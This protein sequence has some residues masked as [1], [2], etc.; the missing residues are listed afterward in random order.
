MLKALTIRDLAIVREL[1]VEF[2][3]GLTVITGETGAGKS[4]LVDA[5]GL[6]LG[7][8]ADSGS[9][10]DGAERATVTA[11][12][13]LSSRPDLRAVLA[14]NDL[15]A[16]DD[17]ILRRV[18]GADGRSRAFC[19]ETP[20]SVQFLKEFGSGLVGIHGQHAHHSLLE[21]PAQRRL[22]DEFGGCGALVA[23]VAGAQ[24]ACVALAGELAAL[25][26]EH[27]NAASRLDFLRFQIDELAGLPLAPDALAALEAEH[28]KAANIERLQAGCTDISQ[29][30]FGDTRG[31]QR[32]LTHALHGAQELASIDNQ[33][34]PLVELLEQAV[35]NLDEAERELSHYTGRLGA[36]GADLASLD[37]ALADLHAAA[38]KHRCEP[39][40][41]GPFR[42]QLQRELETLINHEQIEG[43]TAARLQLAE[44]AFQ[45][46]AGQLSAAR[47][48]AG[49]TLDAAV[50]THLHELALP[51]ARFH[52]EL[53]RSAQATEHGVDEVEL[54]IA[55]N[56]DQPLRP[57]RKV[58]SGGELSRISLA[59]Q[60][61]T[62]GVSGVP[63]LVYDEVDSG[64]S[65]RVAG[66]LARLLEAIAVGRQVLCIT[67]MPQV[68]A[69]GGR[70]LLIGK[71][72]EAGITRTAVSYLSADDRVRE[73][74]RMLGSEPITAKTLAHAREMLAG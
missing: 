71:S 18:V 45:G 55:A 23:A 27:A 62:A 53:S 29:R 48:A 21:R 64:V 10:R 70:H 50:C 54:L 2:T 59:I 65:G 66:V 24:R 12:F 43:D 72:V 41:L 4:I 61:A 40:A 34:T 26:G 6:T 73:L 15:G 44:Q 60:V 31:A 39:A 13:D 42:Q 33:L 63:M 9:V 11:L 28:R 5:L 20:V 47:A 58:A 67:H 30:L 38:R 25:R 8:R 7:D 52:T 14:L 36:A 32:G 68:A 69:A 17:C 35:I 56:P 16:A 49:N 46:L 51:H 3:A 57:L 74:A 22:L 37:R 19:N 1:D